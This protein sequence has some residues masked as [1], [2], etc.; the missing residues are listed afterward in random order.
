MQGS[1]NSKQT[2]MA[3]QQDQRPLIGAGHSPR[4]PGM[5]RRLRNQQAL[6]QQ[7]EAM[8]Q[9]EQGAGMKNQMT[10]KFS[11]SSVMEAQQDQ[12]LSNFDTF[13][14]IAG[15]ELGALRDVARNITEND[16]EVNLWEIL[17]AVN[18]TVRKNPDSS[19]AQLM[20]KFENKYLNGEGS[21]SGIHPAEAVYERSLSSLLFLSMGI[22]LL[23]SV[24]E[25]VP[26]TG[27]RSMPTNLAL[28]NLVKDTE[29]HQEVFQLFNSTEFDFFNHEDGKNLLNKLKPN[30]AASTVNSYIR[31][32]M[33]L[34]NAYIKDGSEFEC[35]Y[36][37]Y[38]YEVNQQASMGGME[39]SVA[40]INSVGLQL[41]LKEISTDDTIPALMRSLLV[42]QDLPCQ[43]MFPTCDL[44]TGTKVERS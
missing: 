27:A 24:N 21:M 3:S 20:G 6:R 39:S 10:E 25:L 8:Q 12:I 31:L 44:Q 35:I 7:M 5:R 29:R 13:L 18:E 15:S 43:K 38:C 34:I 32:V 36:A 33:N 11:P 22:F 42:W 30:N 9:L 41:A 14:K 23:N 2:V 28:S 1:L 16:S 17:A 40:K 4:H 19:I 26:G 37:A